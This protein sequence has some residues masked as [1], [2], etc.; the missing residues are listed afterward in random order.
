MFVLVGGCIAHFAGHDSDKS[1]STGTEHAPTTYSAPTT[2]TYSEHQIESYVIR[3]CQKAV[4]K[5]LKDPD[6]AKFGDDWKAWIV[7]HYDT[8]PKVTNYHPENG[9]KLYSAAGGVNAKNGF[10][11]Y[12]G[13]EPYGC[14]ASVTPGAD[15]YAFAYPL[16]ELLNPD[17]DDLPGSP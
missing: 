1:S 13:D 8:P 6:S 7:T 9:D 16:T 11:G 17:H 14:D 10:G 5:V 15:V 4:K 12:V 2:P 3:T